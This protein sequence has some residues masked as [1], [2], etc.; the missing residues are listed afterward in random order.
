MLAR[1]R[2]RA[3]YRQH[4]WAD[5]FDA[6]SRSDRLAPLGADD[7][8]RLAWSAWLTGRD[9]ELLHALE[10]RYHALDRADRYLA[11]ARTAFWLWRRLSATDQR[12]AAA[13]WLARAQRLLALS[14]VDC[15]ERGYLLLAT[16]E[17]YLDAGDSAAA[18]NVAAEAA[19]IGERFADPDLIA[20]A[21]HLHGRALVRQGHTASGLALIAHA[22]K[23]ARDNRLSPLVTGLVYGGAIET[24]QQACAL[25]RAIEWSAA[26]EAWCDRETE[27]TCFTGICLLHRIERARLTGH[28]REALA[29]ATHACAHI[30]AEADPA[31]LADACYQLAEMHRLRGELVAADEAYRRAAHLGR[32]PQPGLSLLRLAQGHHDTA[33]GAIRQALVDTTTEW[34]RPR[35]L[36]AGVEILLATGE[37]YGTRDVCR[38]LE[39]LARHFD[40]AF[41]KAMA[42]EARG[43]LSIAEGAPARAVGLL[44]YAV[45]VWNQ[46]GALYP[47]A[48]VRTL[49][50][51]AWVAMGDRDGAERELEAARSVLKQV[52]ARPDLA[53]LDEVELAAAD[54]V[55]SLGLSRRELEVLRLVA[56][57][58]TNKEIARDLIVS[59]RTVDHHLSSILNKL[60]LSSRTDATAFAH[61]HALV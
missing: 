28:W 31:T 30:S 20:L 26:L 19:T 54:P 9:R 32:E 43:A 46:V 47:A 29:A 45:Q 12:E 15:T 3:T 36:L 56:T 50:A 4:R 53:Q 24:C 17:R 55:L 60:E 2:G 39:E 13:D 52:G 21:R 16:I 22:V 58:K 7:L 6:L 10:R 33:V 38:E 34:R 59:E 44:R 23:A 11:A 35:L 25:D 14:D 41:L 48:R 49:L 18:R 5:A 1:V 37:T 51:R 42:A 27:M 61:Q 8:E 57:G 40:T